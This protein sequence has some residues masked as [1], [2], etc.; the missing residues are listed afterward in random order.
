MAELRKDTSY[1]NIASPVDLRD[2]VAEGDAVSLKYAKGHFAGNP[3]VSAIPGTGEVPSWNGTAWVYRSLVAQVEPHPVGAVAEIGTSPFFSRADHV[4]VGGSG[5]AGGD[6]QHLDMGVATYTPGPVTITPNTLAGE[7]INDL[8]YALSLMLPEPPPTLSAIVPAIP[9]L[10]T[11]RM[12]AGMA[13]VGSYSEGIILGNIAFSP[14]FTVGYSGFGPADKGTLLCGTFSLNLASCFDETYRTSQ[15]GV[16]Y[17]NGAGLPYQTSVFSV[18]Y[19][20]RQAYA[21]YQVG[22]VTVGYILES[23]YNELA[24]SHTVGADVFTSAS[25]FVWFDDG[26]VPAAPEATVELVSEVLNTTSGIPHFGA[27]TVLSF[28]TPAIVGVF[29]NTYNIDG[30]FANLTGPAILPITIGISSPNVSGVSSP[31]PDISDSPNLEGFRVTLTEPTAQVAASWDLGLTTPR[32]NS[33]LT[34]TM[35]SASIN[36]NTYP[37][38]STGLTEYFTDEHYRLSCMGAG[39]YPTF[40]LGESWTVADLVAY[41]NAVDW[42]APVAT[43]ELILLGGALQYANMNLSGCSPEG[44]NYANRSGWQ[45]YTRYWEVDPKSNLVIVLPPSILSAPGLTLQL[46]LPGVT[47]WL[48]PLSPYMGGTPMANGDGCLVGVTSEVDGWLNI[49]ITLGFNSTSMSN[50]T[51]ITRL[52]VTGAFVP[53]MFMSVC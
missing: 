36:I 13:N 21:G 33:A 2:P 5:G 25:G 50:N 38:R 39:P 11:G 24:C 28:T 31:I 8:N 43:S 7:V 26:F 46:K 22:D 34:P 51:V 27:G 49:P 30:S 47:G 29:N 20:S 42:F 32:G 3:V 23:G 35:S 15:Q 16:S 19:V 4:H 53:L 14:T 45:G 17:A 41:H 48:N 12:A 40:N 44:P 6:A 9:T 37:G 1:A 18:N 10:T 52:G